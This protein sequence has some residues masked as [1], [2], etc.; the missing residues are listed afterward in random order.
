MTPPGF[1]ADVVGAR[2]RLLADTLDDLEPLRGAS[3]SD[4][5]SDPIVRAATERFIQV[6]VDLAVDINSHILVSVAGRTPPT[7]RG[8]FLE[9]GSAA[10]LDPELAARLAPSAGMR[11]LLVHRYADIDVGIVADAIDE[12]LDGYARYV[13]GIGTWLAER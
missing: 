4:L 10:V 2:L 7:A 3:A 13:S 8:T 11:N 12:I 5:A 9:L 6:I 1:D